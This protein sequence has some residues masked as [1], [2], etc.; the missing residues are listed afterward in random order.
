MSFETLVKA[1]ISYFNS[2]EML[3]G[4]LVQK[5]YGVNPA[6]APAVVKVLTN[7]LR[8]FNASDEDFTTMDKYNPYQM[9]NY[10]YWLD[11][12]PLHSNLRT[13]SNKGVHLEYHPSSSGGEWI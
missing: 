2:R 13:L 4:L 10:G 12:P 8:T 7:Y 1:N 11:Y 3:F 6:S 5:A 9:A